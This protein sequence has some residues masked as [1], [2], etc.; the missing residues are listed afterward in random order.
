MGSRSLRRWSLVLGILLLV[1]GVAAIGVGLAGIGPGRSATEDVRTPSPAAT[2]TEPIVPPPPTPAA[3]TGSNLTPTNLTGPSQQ[4]TEQK[5][6]LAP[7]SYTLGQRLGVGAASLPVTVD[8]ADRL[9]FGWYVDWRARKDAFRSTTVE[10]VPMIRLRDGHADPGGDELA[11]TVAA[12]PGALWL[13]GNEPD[14]R[15][16]DGI[17]AD[18]Y[19]RL[20]H[21]LYASLKGL[22]PTCQVAAGGVS[23]PTPMRLAY[24]DLVLKAYEEQ[25]GEPM[26]VDVWNVHNFVLREERDGWGVDIPPGMTE[27]VGV[28]REIAE[29]DDVRIFQQ[30]IVEMRRWMKER[31]EQDKPLIVSEFGILM[32]EDYGFPPERVARFLLDTFSFFRTAVD[33]DIGYAADGNRLVQRWCWYSLADTVYP[34]ANLVSLDSGELTMIGGAFR[35]YADSTP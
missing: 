5:P 25:Y 26:P 21:D 8:L 3:A 18:T 33:P 23:Q 27:Q 6:V 31:G 24:L 19:A 20:Y 11:A 1:G 30:Q 28:L 12:N 17:T 10:Y 32:P 13:I 22:D 2:A 15:W 34:T 35:T 4:A 16:Q 14:V 7:G 9:G 29:H